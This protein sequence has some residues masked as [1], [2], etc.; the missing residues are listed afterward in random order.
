MAQVHSIGPLWTAH[1]ICENGHTQTMTLQG[2]TR[3]QAE[4]FAGLLDGT[5][6][7]YQ[8][9]PCD[10]ERSSIGRCGI[11]GKPFKVEIVEQKTGL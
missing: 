2:Y 8:T 9:R 3:E 7:A 10:D 4:L 5:S 1:A 6:P 11:C